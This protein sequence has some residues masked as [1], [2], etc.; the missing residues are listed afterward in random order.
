MTRELRTPQECFSD[1]LRFNKRLIYLFPPFLPLI[2]PKM[3]ILR[4][5][6]RYNYNISIASWKLQF[7]EHGEDFRLFIFLCNIVHYCI[8]KRSYFH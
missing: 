8:E 4:N 7:D 1:K 5:Y 2:N 6:S 3:S